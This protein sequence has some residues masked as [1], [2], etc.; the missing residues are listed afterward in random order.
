M[1]PVRGKRSPQLTTG[2]ISSSC[3]L[4]F[5]RERWFALVKVDARDLE[6]SL[7]NSLGIDVGTRH[8]QNTRYPPTPV[9]VNR[10]H[11]RL[12]CTVAFPAPRRKLSDVFSEDVSK[13][14]VVR[15]ALRRINHC[16]SIETG[17]FVRYEVRAASARTNARFPLAK[18]LAITA[19]V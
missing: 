5:R 1:R 6:A 14:G 8:D 19:P 11:V 10:T 2:T 16:N 12:T 4:S 15:S 13:R 3:R 18:S 17:L 9:H 7:W